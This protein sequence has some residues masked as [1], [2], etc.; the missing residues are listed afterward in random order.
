MRAITRKFLPTILASSVLL[1]LGADAGF[2]VS[3]GK[4]YEGNGNEFV[5]RG[6]NHAH[7]WFPD[8]LDQSLNGIAN[9]GTNTVRV[10]LSSGDRWTK[11]SA[12]DVA[13]LLIKLKKKI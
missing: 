12:N 4:I 2:L 9:T 6:I 5:M 13:T 7:T 3:G 1:S 8:K 11:N 10:V